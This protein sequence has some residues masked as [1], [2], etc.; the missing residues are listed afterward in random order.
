[1]TLKTHFPFLHNVN[2]ILLLSMALI[3]NSCGLIS[4]GQRTVASKQQVTELSE[5]EEMEFTRLFFDGNKAKILGDFGEAKKYFQQALRIKPESAAVQFELAKLLAEQGR[6]NEALQLA[7]SARESD[8]ENIWYA[9]F[10][11]QL[12]A[13]T[14]DFDKSVDIYRDIIKS[15]PEEY[16]N[17]F[18]LAG[19]LSAQ[20][21]FKE[22]LEIFDNLEKQIGPSEDISVQRQMIYLE[23]GEMDKALLEVSAL[24]DAN[25]AEIRYYGMKAEILQG[26]NRTEEAR[27]LYEMMLFESPD[28]GLVLLALYELSEKAAQHDKAQE[29]LL[30][31][32][33]SRDLGIDIKVNI[34]LNFLAAGEIDKRPELVVNLGNSLE[35]A[36]PDDAKSYAIQGDILYNLQRFEEAREKFRK[37]VA[38]DA[39]RPPIWQQ[40][41]TISSQIN[42]FEAMVSE[43]EEAME[44]FPMQPIFYL[45]HGVA[46]LQLKQVDQAIESLEGGSS[47]IVDNEGLKAQ[48]YSSLGDAYHELKK[49]EESDAYYQKA[50]DIDGSNALVLNNYAYY[51]SLRGVNLDKAEEMA[52]KANN[53]APDTPSFQDT[54][55]WV[56]H[57]RGNHRNAL[58]WIEQ[59]L[60]NGAENDPVVL[61]HYGDV[62]IVLDRKADAVRA[63]QQA[64]DA[65]GNQS[66]LLPKINSQNIG[67]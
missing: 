56:L 3:L 48:F 43:G 27:E 66:E 55:G 60:N 22:A 58:F 52:K 18:N 17:Y 38:L 46:L 32:F 31:A 19:L 1:M 21:K 9:H 45:F 28:N 11:A 24:I 44:L 41:L 54:Y 37:A 2:A 25:P 16:E 57:K 62:L 33:N 42:D 61:E 65:G 39:N 20:G 49:H 59:A 13:E 29:Y 34:L 36:H 4:G 67:E 23:Q 30:R 40:I 15:Q 6:Y 64:L 26:M 14:G 12:Y 8:R 47:L 63:W 51:L 7:S 5:K 53:L 50:L 35:N 10:V